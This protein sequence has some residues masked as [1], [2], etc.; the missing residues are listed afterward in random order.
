MKKILAGVLILAVCLISA[1]VFA[2]WPF[3]DN[4]WTPLD[5]YNAAVSGGDDA[6]IL[7]TGESLLPIVEGMPD[8][9]ERTNLLGTVYEKL[10]R[11]TE[12]LGLF[13]KAV[14]YNEKYIPYGEKLGWT[15]GVTFAQRKITG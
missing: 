15:D 6:A 12:N 13:D 14:D 8:S 2:D 5:Q 7:T 1:P 9:Q 10:A 3:P 11:T 4:I